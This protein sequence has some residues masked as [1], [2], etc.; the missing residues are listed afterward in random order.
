MI[1]LPL[2]PQMQRL[3][4]S[5]D[6]IALRDH[7]DTSFLD[8]IYRFGAA[9]AQQHAEQNRIIGELRLSSSQGIRLQGFAHRRK[10][11]R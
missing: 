8:R 10:S 9:I 1:A 4:S 11:V 2:Y 3:Q 5:R 7:C 6:Q